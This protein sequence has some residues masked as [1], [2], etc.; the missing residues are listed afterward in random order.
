MA[1]RSVATGHAGAA[2]TPRPQINNGGRENPGSLS[3]GYAGPYN[4]L[5]LQ[6]T[7]VVQT[8]GA[9]GAYAASTET[10]FLRIDD[11]TVTPFL[12]GLSLD[13]NFSWSSSLDDGLSIAQI[14]RAVTVGT[15]SNGECA[16]TQ[17]V[18][19]E[20]NVRLESVTGSFIAPEIDPTSAA[21]ALMLLFGALVVL[22]GRRPARPV[23]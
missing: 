17:I 2:L 23:V 15:C 4:E 19:A 7:Q 1:G 13:Q 8:T 21:S 20:A 11:A 16:G 14:E 12:S 9:N 22:R 6:S 18:D 10:S 3:S 5:D